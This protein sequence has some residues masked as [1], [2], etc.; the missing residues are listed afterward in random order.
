[1]SIILIIADCV[2]D[3]TLA[4]ELNFIHWLIK[5]AVPEKHTINS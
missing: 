5:T 1:M 4:S 3:T 2:V